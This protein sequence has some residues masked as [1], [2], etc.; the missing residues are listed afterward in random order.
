MRGGG[1]VVFE[2]VEGGAFEEVGFG[3]FLVVGGEFGFFLDLG[4]CPLSFLN[5]GLLVGFRLLF[6]Y[7]RF[8]FGFKVMVI[9]LF[10]PL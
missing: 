1:L 4:S 10:L 6:I 2:G 3:L 8:L 5:D 9:L 7:D